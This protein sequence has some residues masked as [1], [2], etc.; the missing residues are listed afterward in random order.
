L[1]E[2]EEEGNPVGE[3]TVSV[4]MDLEISQILE[5]QPASIK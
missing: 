1:E 5:H 2:A 4:N 3:P